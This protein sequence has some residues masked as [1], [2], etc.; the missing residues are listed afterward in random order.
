MYGK[1]VKRITALEAQVKR[2]EAVLLSGTPEPVAAP[3]YLTLTEEKIIR[4]LSLGDRLN[5]D[6]LMAMTGVS[7][8]QSIRAMINTLR[9][10]GA[11]IENDYRHGYIFKGWNVA[12]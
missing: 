8:P 9:R 1:H 2:L 10:K 11:S 6:R 7:T 5:N 12:A 3:L 4:A